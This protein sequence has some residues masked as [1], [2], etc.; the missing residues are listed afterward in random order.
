M[1]TTAA[2]PPLP[3]F[4][5]DSA[6]KKVRAAE[7]GWN[8]R[9]PARIALAYTPGSRWRNRVE[10]SVGRDEIILLLER[11]WRRELSYRLIKELRGCEGNRIAVRFAYE[12]HDEAG[13]WYRSY[14]NRNWEFD[15][16]DAG[17]PCQHQRTTDFES[18]R[19]FHWP[20]GGRPDGHPGLAE[21]GL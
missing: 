3:P 13:N 7:D 1:T 8:T 9:D 4:S 12:W 17:A 6:I 11:K 19:K 5:T 21:L 18:Q 2:R 15:Q 10:F 16:S 20:F 14:G